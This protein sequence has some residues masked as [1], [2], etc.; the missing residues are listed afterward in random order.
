[1]KPERI[2]E[3]ALRLGLGGI[4]IY[5]GIAKLGDVQQF[6]LDIH[7]FEL[8]PSDVS[9]VFAV[10]LPWLEIVLGVALVVR[11]LYLGAIG[12]C[13]LLALVFLGAIGSAWWRGLDITCGCFGHENNASNFPRHLALNG[14]MLAATMGLAWLER[15]RTLSQP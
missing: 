11:R 3:W 7:H 9:M 10:F 2:L 5:A 6:Y 4:F 13:A 8:T 12:L 1:M 15:R 14:A